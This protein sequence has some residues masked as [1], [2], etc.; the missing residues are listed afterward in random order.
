MD[1]YSGRLRH[2]L[3]RG[4]RG[5]DQWDFFDRP[6]TRPAPEGR[7]SAGGRRFADRPKRI[8]RRAE[9]DRFSF[10]MVPVIWFL[11]LA[12]L[13]A[14][15]S[16]GLHASVAGEVDRSWWGLAAIPLGAGVFLAIVRVL[17][18]HFSG[19]LNEP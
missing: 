17:R 14:L 4:G 13:A 18:G 2:F 16:L 9:R 19:E 6:V 8:A 15:G 3:G 11:L 12:G 1:C 7:I 5:G 10:L